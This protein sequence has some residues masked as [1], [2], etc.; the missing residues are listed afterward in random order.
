MT[1]GEDYNEPE[2]ALEELE[3]LVGVPRS[4]FL[5]LIKTF[6]Y[7]LKRTSTF[8]IKPTKLQAELRE[9][10]KLSDDKIDAIIRL[11]I[12]NTKP[13]MENLSD[14]KYESNE[15]KDVAWKLNVQIS[16]HCQQRQKTALAVLQLK[17]G[18][19]EDINLEM[20][21]NDLL[22]LYNQ[23]ENIQNELDAMRCS[24]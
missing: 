21:H 1:P 4:D 7:I 18:A 3:K 2:N 16:S 11:W 14:E 22:N 17:T 10:L 20:N 5:L 13:I 9:K 24:K 23:F 15:I 6:S 19:G 8:V 12:K